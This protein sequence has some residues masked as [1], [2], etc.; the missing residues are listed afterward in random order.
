MSILVINK[1]LAM[2]I[3]LDTAQVFE[4]I[5]FWIKENERKSMTDRTFTNNFQEGRWWT[6]NSIAK[7]Q[8]NEFPFWSVDKVRREFK[9]LLQLGYIISGNFNKVKWDRSK[10]YTINYDVYQEESDTLT[11]TTLE[12]VNVVKNYDKKTPGIASNEMEFLID[13]FM[14]DLIEIVDREFKLDTDLKS[15]FVKLFNNFGTDK[16]FSS[17][18]NIKNSHYLIN[19]LQ[20]DFFTSF[21]GFGKII[22]DFYVDRKPENIMPNAFVQNNEMDLCKMPKPI[23]ESS[24]EINYSLKHHHQS[25]DQTDEDDEILNAVKYFNQNMPLKLKGDNLSNFKQLCKEY[26]VNKVIDAIKKGAEVGGRSLKYIIAILKNPNGKPNNHKNNKYFQIQSHNWNMEKIEELERKHNE[27]DWYAEKPVI[28]TEI[29][30]SAISV[31]INESAIPVEINESANIFDRIDE[32]NKFNN[33]AIK[34]SL[35]ILSDDNGKANIIEKITTWENSENCSAKEVNSIEQQNL[36]DIEQQNLA[37][38][39]QQNLADIDNRMDKY[40]EFNTDTIDYLDYLFGTEI[41]RKQLFDKLTAWENSKDCST[42]NEITV[43]VANEQQNIIDP[44][45]P[46]MYGKSLED[47]IYGVNRYYVSNEGYENDKSYQDDRNYKDDDFYEDDNYCE[48]NNFYK[49]DEVFG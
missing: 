45:K 47:I 4:K 29:N 1:D 15:N 41:V 9:K 48:Y 3:G 14:N 42:K 30:E 46:F 2:K 6:Y 37:D 32:Y 19:N 24:S 13:K 17:L 26:T 33:N 38:I 12:E 22:S 11:E 25:P 5:K 10:W 23:P 40:N 44:T 39:E 36:A 20:L 16:V 28:K 21:A 27:G 49:E 35:Y 34:R 8:K 7:W 31:E 43:A 18:N